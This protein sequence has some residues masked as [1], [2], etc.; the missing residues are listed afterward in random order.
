MRT[1]KNGLLAAILVGAVALPGHRPGPQILHAG[2]GVDRHRADQVQMQGYQY[3]SKYR[4][5]VGTKFARE[6][7]L[8]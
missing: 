8:K 5:L 4:E 7:V 6:L 1:L 3:R 2:N